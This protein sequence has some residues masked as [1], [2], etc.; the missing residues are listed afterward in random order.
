[1]S[2]DDETT[3]IKVVYLEKLCNFVVDKFFIQIH[4][5][6]QLTKLHLICYNM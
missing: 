2:S 1:M 4:L 5:V 6:P 3:N